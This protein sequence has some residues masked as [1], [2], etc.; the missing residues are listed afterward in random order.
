MQLGIDRCKLG[1]ILVGSRKPICCEE[2]VGDYFAEHLEKIRHTLVKVEAV[3]P[4]ILKATGI[5]VTGRDR[6]LRPDS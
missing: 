6:N 1:D 5:P 3:Q 2:T 4:V